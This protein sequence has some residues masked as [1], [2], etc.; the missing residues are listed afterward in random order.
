MYPGSGE[1]MALNLLVCMLADKPA[2]ERSSPHGEGRHFVLNASH[3]QDCARE[4]VNRSIKDKKSLKV[5]GSG[6]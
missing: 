2:F 6:S 1:G 4:T 5:V 3:V